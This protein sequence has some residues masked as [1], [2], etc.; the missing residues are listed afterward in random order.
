MKCPKCQAENSE[1]S[2]FCAECGTQLGGHETQEPGIGGQGIRGHVPDSLESGTCPPNYSGATQTLRTP[3]KELTRGTLFA[4]RFEVIEELGKGGMGKVYRVF[5]KKVEEEVALK[6]VKPE[7]A[8]DREVIDRFRNELKLSRK[9]SHRNVSRMYDLGDE[10]G[11]YYITM[12]Y[13]PGEDLK[14]FIHRSR[15]LNTGTAVSI[16]RQVAEGLAEAH[17]LGIVHRDLKP[18]NIMIDKEGSAKIMDFGIARSLAGQG[19]TGAGTMIGTP[20]YMSPEQVEGKDVDQRSDIYSL[21]VVLYE[22][23]TGRRPFGG[24]TPL[25]VAHKQKYE[26]PEDPGQLNAQI[27]DDLS[28]LILRC[29]E[30]DKEERY[31]SAEELH[32][33]LT[34]LEEEIPTTE[35]AV[36][37]KKPTKPREIAADA[38]KINWAK[39]GLY[40]GALIVLALI[41]YAGF[42]FFAGRHEIIDSIAVLPFENVNADP[43]MDYLCD[44]IAE[45]IINKLSQLSGFKTVINRASAFTYKGK[46]V[47]PKKVGRELGVKAV[48]LTRMVRTG[49]QLT[50]SPTLVRAEDGGQ[51]WGERYERKSEDILSLEENIATSVVQALHLKMTEKDQQTISKR[52]INNAAAYEYY[53]RAIQEIERFREDALDRAIQYLQSGLG[54]VGDN[55]LLYSATA[56]AYFQYANLGVKPEEYIPK[57]EEY[58][59]KALALDP[60]SSKA[61]V[62]LGLIE[63]RFQGDQKASVRYLKKALSLS[64]DDPEALFWLAWIYCQRVGKISEAIPF[65]ERFARVDPMNILVY[66]AWGA[67]YVHDGRFDLALKPLSQCYQ[68]DPGNVSTAAGYAMVLL[69]EGKIDDASTVIDQMVKTYRDNIFT[70]LALVDKYAVLNDQTNL[71]KEM[72]PDFVEA[73]R[74]DGAYSHMIASALALI[75]EKEKALDW[76]E[77]AVNRGFINYPILAEKDPWLASIR[78]E[79]RFKKL[80]ERVKYEWEHFEE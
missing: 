9:I 69:Y 62:V 74:R 65:V 70:K 28:R 51:V 79:A 30:K 59:R 3:V 21:G 38:G 35:S 55:T 26:A 45:T 27:P 5:D 52:E 72:T 17:R 22:M 34:R 41:V 6:L 2:R 43:D 53:L 33:E 19:I 20:E 4:R 54:L 10:E 18:S 42:H 7:I 39:I 23:V 64:P 60:S 15:Q 25:S 77:N 16:A 78:G 13:V 24:D 47:D 31:Q 8:A 56:Y 80:M 63:T 57:A 32:G 67:V 12:E 61:L 46:A 40:G 44:G 49:D 50:V 11:T 37:K 58:A 71:F 75:G 76:L 36:P 48:L 73:F 68:M 29:L 66:Y 1:T 14:S